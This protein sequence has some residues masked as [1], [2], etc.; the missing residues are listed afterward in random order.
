MRAN[1]FFSFLLFFR[2]KQEK[3]TDMQAL[4]GEVHW[5][6][7]ILSINERSWIM[8]A[9]Y[10]MYLYIKRLYIFWK[11]K[12]QKQRHRDRLNHDHIYVVNLI[13]YNHNEEN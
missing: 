8:D 12:V 5:K 4:D 13:N 10:P 1:L 6:Q 3:G 2:Q 9:L 11:A 7:S